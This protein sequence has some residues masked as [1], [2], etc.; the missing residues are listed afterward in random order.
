MTHPKISDTDLFVVGGGPAGIAAA[1][2]TRQRGFRTIVADVLHG[3]IDKA[4]GEGLMPDSLAELNGLG[5]SLDGYRHGTFRSIRF[6]GRDT[7]VQADFPT[8]CGIGVR[9]TTLH[10][11]LAE[12]AAR[13]G[14]EF[15]WGARVDGIDSDAVHVS[16]RKI[17]SRWIIGA[18]GQNSL[19]RSWAQL[20]AGREYE[21]RIAL[22]QHFRVAKAPEYVE[23]Y[24]ADDSQ[25]YVT[26]VAEDEICVAIISKRRLGKFE[27]ELQR[28]PALMAMLAHTQPTT[29]VRGGLSLSNRLDHVSRGNVALVGDASGCVDA[30]TGEGLALSFRHALALAEA[31]AKNDLPSY[32]VA[33]SRIASLPQFMRRAMLLMDKSSLLRRRTLA[34]FQE[35][36]ALFERMLSVH[37][38]ML[39]LMDFGAGALARFGWQLVT[40]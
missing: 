40:A 21:R 12:Q 1:L 39:P 7:S 16:G 33:H 31:L 17:R 5:V 20:G 23:I 36:P 25:A 3:P 6:V 13:A 22:R 15:L 14:V 24:W 32:E 10:A 27:E 8:G 4:C 2:A 35:R 28:I 9:R 37:V 19:V 30:I 18:D 38:G 26:P 34:A 29:T 11:V